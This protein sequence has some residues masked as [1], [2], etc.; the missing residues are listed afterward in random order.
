M[1]THSALCCTSYWWDVS[2][3]V[4]DSPA[5][6][7]AQ[8]LIADPAPPGRIDPSIP[9]A[10]S[11]V[12]MRALARDPAH[13]YATAADL[14]DALRA[15]FDRA[16]PPTQRLPLSARG[17]HGIRRSVA[18]VALA[19]VATLT[20]LSGWRFSQP[21]SPTAREGSSQAETAAIAATATPQPTATPDTAP[22]STPA[23]IVG[24][25]PPSVRGPVAVP[26]GQGKKK[27]GDRD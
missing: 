6:V 5:S 15:A 26:H 17:K 27:G 10:L 1:S 18:V 11:S 16:S 14:R 25:A 20:V 19:T 23:A 21:Q 24:Q 9:P 7:A 3:F 13:R 22:P 4:A 2:R 12:V 8:R